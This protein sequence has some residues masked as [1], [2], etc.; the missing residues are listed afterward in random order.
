MAKP[1]PDLSDEQP[2]GNKATKGRRPKPRLRVAYCEGMLSFICFR[3][4]AALAA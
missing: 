3:A 1:T 4:A 2:M